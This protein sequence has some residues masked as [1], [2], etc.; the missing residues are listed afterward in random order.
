MIEKIITHI[1]KIIRFNRFSGKLVCIY[2]GL[3]V[4]KL[5]LLKYY[6]FSVYS[7]NAEN[8]KA[9][10]STEQ[11]I[12]FFGK[13]E[14]S[15]VI[16]RDQWP[17]QAL[18]QVETGSGNLCTATLITP[19]LALTAGHYVLIPPGNI[20]EAIALRFVAHQNHWQYQ[21]I[22]LDTFVDVDL[23]SKLQ[24]SDKG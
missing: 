16:N 2:F 24:A 9:E 13:D 6:F 22:Q 4:K 11:T 23:D 8:N 1:S 19:D 3:L 14:R 10:T 12:S 17:W 7:I 18:A 5:L 15:A 21:I 20:D